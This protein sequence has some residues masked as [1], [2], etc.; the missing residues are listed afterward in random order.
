MIHTTDDQELVL[1]LNDSSIGLAPQ[2][3]E[4]DN[5]LI[6][7]LVLQRMNEQIPKLESKPAPSADS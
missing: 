2:H 5:R 4:A 1:E 6:K 7:E 3:V